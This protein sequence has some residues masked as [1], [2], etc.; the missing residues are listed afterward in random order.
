MGTVR[1]SQN[2]VVARRI[3]WRR[4]HHL[5]L[6]FPR[7][8]G[9][10]WRAH[11]QAA[12]HH[13]Q[14]ID[15]GAEEQGAKRGAAPLFDEGDSIQVM[16]TNLGLGVRPDL[17]DPHTIHWHCF[18]ATPPIFDG[19]PGKCRSRCRWGATFP[20][21][22][23]PTDPGTYMYHCHNEDVEHVQ[24]GMTG[25]VFVRPA[26]NKTGNGAGAPVAR[27]GGGASGAPKG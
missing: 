11:R 23:H 6:R 21:Y 5:Y 8:N 1:N 17:Y 14:S 3:R 19:V 20:Y 25:I 9:S 27:D 18:R 16:L 24:M 7:R 2:A 10:G 15:F 13:R 4:A 12:G 26:Q 22:F